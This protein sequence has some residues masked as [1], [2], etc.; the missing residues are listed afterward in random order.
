MTKVLVIGD[1]IKDVYRYS[2]RLGLSAETPTIVGKLKEEKISYGGAYLVHQN[3]LNLNVDSYFLTICERPEGSLKQTVFFKLKN[4][5]ISTKE[6]MFVDQYKLLQFD[7]LNEEKH[8]FQ[9]ENRFLNRI[10]LFIKENKIEEVVLS[11]YRHGVL[12]MFLV[13]R[14]IDFCKKKNIVVYCD[15]Q[16][17]QKDSNHFWYKKSDFMFLN[18]KE[19]DLATKI[20]KTK[21]DNVFC[22][23]Y[24]INNL[25]VKMGTSGA[26]HFYYPNKSYAKHDGYKIDVA[27]TCGA[28]DAFLAA[29]IKYGSIKYANAFAATKC[30][31]KGT[32]VNMKLFEENLKE[33]G[34]NA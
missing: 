33:W 15:S 31:T 26:K 1:V 7:V 16:C 5:K 32:Q 28:G 17:S 2:D 21:D 27:D 3:L 12:S 19:Y 11:D 10:I 24:E 23:H 34:L 8:D 9:T 4:W 20:L 13:V 25:I 6:R 14:L 18:E 22:T 29:F 30:M